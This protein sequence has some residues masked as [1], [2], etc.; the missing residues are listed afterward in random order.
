MVAPHLAPTQNGFSRMGDPGFVLEPALPIFL[1]TYALISLQRFRGFQLNRPMAALFG[2]AL[3]VIFGV[4]TWQGALQA[5]SSGLEILALLLGMMMM[6]ATLEVAGFFEFLAERL[7]ARASSP[8][9]FFV[10]MC[11][12]SAVL[13]ALILND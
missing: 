11:V 6:V 4:V 5:V 9:S 8:R 3:M 7:V 10:Q 1:L 12:A 13:S 2:A